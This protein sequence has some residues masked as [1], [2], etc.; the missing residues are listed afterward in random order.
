MLDHQALGQSTWHARGA[1]GERNGVIMFAEYPD[2][3][4]KYK[5]IDGDELSP[6][7]DAAPD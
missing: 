7:E 4:S 3:K 1:I 6:E 2:N 5:L